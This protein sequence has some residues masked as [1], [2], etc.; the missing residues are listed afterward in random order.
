[1]DGFIKSMGAPKKCE[2]C[3]AISPVIRKE[4]SN[5]LFQVASFFFVHAAN[6]HGGGR[7][8]RRGP[9]SVVNVLA[10]NWFRRPLLGEAS[11]N[12]GYSHVSP[13]FFDGIK[14][15]PSGQKILVS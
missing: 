12:L 13:T 11:S 14:H 1:M 15:F 8:T 4:G 2:N 5:K 9:H 7:E 6:G 10:L 3:G